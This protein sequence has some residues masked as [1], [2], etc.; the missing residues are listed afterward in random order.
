LSAIYIA[1]LLVTT[2][3]YPPVSII[4]FTLNSTG[5]AIP[6]PTTVSGTAVNST[7]AFG[8]SHTTITIPD[9][10]AVGWILPASQGWTYQTLG[11]W[12][13][14][15][16]GLQLNEGVASIGVATVGATLPV[17][18]TATYTGIAQSVIVDPVG[19]T[20]SASATMNATAD[21]GTRAVAFSTTGSQAAQVN[22][23][24]GAIGP[25]IATPGIDMTGTLNYAAGSNAFTGAITTT[26]AMTGTATGRFYG[27]GIAAATGTKAI[28]S[29][30]E[31]GG[32]Y[33]AS[34]GG[35]SMIGAFGGK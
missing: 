9:T 16:L 34:G 29:P 8:I 13:N 3:R 11:G 10:R 31:I 22:L 28:G 33:K 1:R 35:T 6:N 12:E 2:D 17:V 26:S 20:F 27:P 30:P 5:S 21:F 32:V 7:D 25:V 4:E 15:T 18:G 19:D 23:V 24:T 14:A